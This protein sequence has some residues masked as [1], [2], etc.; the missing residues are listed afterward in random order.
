MN[1]SPY[2]YLSKKEL[3]VWDKAKR[4]ACPDND[5]EQNHKICALCLGTIVFAAYVECQPNSDFKWNIDHII[6]KKRFNSLIGEAIKRKIVSVN[7]ERNLQIVHVSCNEIKGD[8]FNSN[9]I[10]GY[11]I[12]EY[13]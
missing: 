12:I 6:P 13:N 10:N 7:D 5:C 8:N 3:G 4:C 2:D 1:C 9:E 11:G